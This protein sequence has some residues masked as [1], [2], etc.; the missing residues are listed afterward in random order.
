[1]PDPTQGLTIGR[2]AVQMAFACEMISNDLAG[3]I[4][5]QT[6]MDGLAATT[7]PATTAQLFVVFSFLSQVPKIV[8]NCRIVIEGERGE[9]IAE[10]KVKDLAFTA[11]TQVARNVV[12]FQGVTWPQPGRYIV[13]FYG[14][15]NDVLAYFPLLVQQAPGA[16]NVPGS[17]GGGMQR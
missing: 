3:R 14:N 16:P 15:A 11:D 8:V 13:K 2:P 10:A 4:S 17:P 5:F 6:L 9:V 7:F 12:G 1:M